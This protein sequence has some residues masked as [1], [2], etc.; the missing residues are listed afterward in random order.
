MALVAGLGSRSKVEGNVVLLH[1]MSA[2]GGCR[3]TDA[4]VLNLATGSEWLR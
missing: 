1:A 4:H 3:G 2:Y